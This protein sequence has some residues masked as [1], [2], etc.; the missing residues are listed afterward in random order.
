MFR[1]RSHD[2]ARK[3]TCNPSM[4]SFRPSRRKP[5]RLLAIGVL[6]GVLCVQL[7]STGT[8]DRITEVG[9]EVIGFENESGRGAFEEH[10]NARHVPRTLYVY[11]TKRIRQKCL[12]L[13]TNV[14]D[15]HFFFFF[16]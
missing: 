10:A 5:L 4:G 1:S 6:R 16:N 15:F 12:F 3:A 8:L 2:R 14:D 7:K 13:S 11:D 9:T